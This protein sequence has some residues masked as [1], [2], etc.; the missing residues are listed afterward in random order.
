MHHQGSYWVEEW[1]PFILRRN[2]TPR[3]HYR[4]I[5]F[6]L[7]N[8]IWRCWVGTANFQ[9]KW[10]K[11]AQFTVLPWRT[12]QNIA[13]GGTLDLHRSVQSSHSAPPGIFA[14]SA[15]G[16]N[17][18]RTNCWNRIIGYSTVDFIFCFNRIR[19]IHFRKRFRAFCS[20]ISLRKEKRK[21][22]LLEQFWKCFHHY[23]IT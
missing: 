10:I 15:T 20:R 2:I 6:A 12:R 23:T 11:K 7:A 17:T 4:S 8:M 19:Q 3:V 22:S 1:S 9:H 13:G 18:V 5:L 21:F 14:V 16:K